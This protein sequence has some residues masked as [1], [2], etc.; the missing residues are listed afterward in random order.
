MKTC[1]KCGIEKK[2]NEINFVWRNDS[3]K[4]RNNCK[5]C[6]NV[7]SQNRYI[8]NEYSKNKKEYYEDNKEK[9]KIEQKEYREEKGSRKEYSRVYQK[10]R[11]KID[12]IYRAHKS[13][14]AQIYVTLQQNGAS[15]NGKSK[16]FLPFTDDEYIS[17]MKT[18]FALPENY[19]MTWDNCGKYNRKTWDDNDQ[20]TWTWQLDHIIPH[21]TFHYTSMDCQEFRDCWALNNL[22]PLSAKQNVLDGVTR[23]RHKKDNK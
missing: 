21:S 9:I 13:I 20:T 11:N 14:S 22:R 1:K 18:Y 5:S 15:K 2:L 17:H 16:K 23:V 3:Q 10:N 19:W 7:D 4:W 12:P 8:N 6:I